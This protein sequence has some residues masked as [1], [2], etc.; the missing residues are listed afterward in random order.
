MIHNRMGINFLKMP[1]GMYAILAATIRMKTSVTTREM[2]SSVRR[3]EGDGS[4][5]TA[6][7]DAGGRDP[8]QDKDMENSQQPEHRQQ[9]ITGQF[10]RDDLLHYFS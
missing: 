2:V 3:L 5:L 4:G 6:P 8:Q 9:K 10:C 1:A 7:Y